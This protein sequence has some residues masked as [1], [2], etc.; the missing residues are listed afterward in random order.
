MEEV[1]TDNSLGGWSE[2]IK[3]RV[4]KKGRVVSKDF[5][6]DKYKRLIKYSEYGNRNSKF[7]WEINHIKPVSKGGADEVHNLQPLHWENSISKSESGELGKGK[8]NK[9]DATSHLYGT[10]PMLNKK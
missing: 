8:L 3:L 9:S 5:N 2:E 4:W 10:F 6:F 7:G 1:N